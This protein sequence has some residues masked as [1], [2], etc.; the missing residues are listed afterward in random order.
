MMSEWGPRPTFQVLP[1]LWILHRTIV[2]QRCGES[3]LKFELH[4]SPTT[5]SVFFL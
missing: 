5:T 3:P 2:A 4:S 1:I